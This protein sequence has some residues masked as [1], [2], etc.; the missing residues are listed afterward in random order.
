MMEDVLARLKSSR[1]R[2][3]LD[4]VKL[5]ELDPK[6]D[7]QYADLRC[8]DF[9]NQDLTEYDF[10]FSDIS[11]SEFSGAQFS[12]ES[13]QNALFF[14]G[15]RYEKLDKTERYLYNSARCFKRYFDR[16]AFIAAF[17]MFNPDEGH[18]ELLNE[19]IRFEKS[20]YAINFTQEIISIIKMETD[21][22]QK[23]REIAE[24][25]LKQSYPFDRP[26]L[27]SRLKELSGTL[28]FMRSYINL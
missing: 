1:S 10:S 28:N 25:A 24:I 19:I 23:R 17:S 7:F 21:A 5:T 12:K 11:G 15:I 18:E 8:S 22:K 26:K 3:F 16:I 4:L 2:K 27:R 20:L 14:N 9:R 6:I 13:F